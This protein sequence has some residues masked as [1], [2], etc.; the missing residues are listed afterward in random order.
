MKYAENVELCLRM[1][2]GLLRPKKQSDMV[3]L[4]DDA[5][6]YSS[7]SSSDRTVWLGTD[8]DS[9]CTLR[10]YRKVL[11]PCT[12]L[13][14]GGC[15]V[16]EGFRRLYILRGL[17]PLPALDLAFVAAPDFSSRPYFK[18][19]E[20][21]D[22]KKNY[23]TNIW[24]L[25]DITNNKVLASTSSVDPIGSRVWKL[26][27]GT[28]GNTEES[29]VEASLSACD[30]EQSACRNGACILKT[31][32]C[33]GYPHCPDGYDE[34]KCEPIRIPNGY[35][36][37]APPP[38]PPADVTVSIEVTR[39]VSTDPLLL[40]LNTF[41]EWEDR[42]LQYANLRTDSDY[43]IPLNNNIWRPRLIVLAQGSSANVAMVLTDDDELNDQRAKS[44][45]KLMATTLATPEMDKRDTAL[46]DT[47]FPGTNTTLTLSEYVLR[48]IDC[49]FDL[50]FYPFDVH[51]CELTLVLVPHSM[52]H[53]R[54][55]LPN[56]G[57]RYTGVTRL[58]DFTFDD[59]EIRNEEVKIGAEEHSGVV[60]SMRLSR[61]SAY[62]MVSVILPSF[63]LLG[64][65]MASLWMTSQASGSTRLLVSCGATGAF[66][67]L[68][69]IASFNSPTTGRV[70]ALDVWLCFCT[71]HSVLLTLLHVFVDIFGP[72]ESPTL[73][74]RVMSRSPSRMR[75]VKPIES[76]SIYDNLIRVP[77]SDDAW[78][79]SYWIVFIARVVSPALVVLFNASFWPFVIYFS[80]NPLP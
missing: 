46:A 59:L 78:T 37:M 33:D 44:S 69:L 34:E 60:L 5:G 43:P 3:A 26:T 50:S 28:C 52:K 16:K 68:W 39:V 57:A 55:V 18:G 40:L 67:A 66:L 71:M 2:M 36:K 63:I 74:S 76:G 20:R 38:K 73:F 9:C 72:T 53:A 29:E 24:E 54:L 70:K 8:D 51:T 17:C 15:Q 42:R 48:P 10:D 19:F 32:R 79:A 58:S 7:C 11:V 14:C 27:A 65:S 35:L 62:I 22:I 64:I 45:L 77:D 1:N 30:V 49:N 47:I 4:S 13:L 75:E 61:H 41:L 12:T 31:S 23:A 6:K 21:Y 80:R 56:N 25:L